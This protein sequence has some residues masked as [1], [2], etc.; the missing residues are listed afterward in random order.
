M[1]RTRA[2]K[3]MIQKLFAHHIHKKSAHKIFVFLTIDHCTIKAHRNLCELS[4]SSIIV[5]I[6]VL[7]V[8]RGLSYVTNCFFWCWPVCGISCAGNIIFLCLLALS[9]LVM[10]TWQRSISRFLLLALNQYFISQILLLRAVASCF[11]ALYRRLI[12]IIVHSPVPFIE[13]VCYVLLN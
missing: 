7:S 12:Q 5:K 13:N 2:L 11:Q 10:Q 3:I 9:Q 4:L 6:K 1:L 8:W